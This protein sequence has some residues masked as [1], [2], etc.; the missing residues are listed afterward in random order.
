MTE[1]RVMSDDEF[2]AVFEIWKR[3]V[4]PRIEAIVQA[5]WDNYPTSTGLS[6]L[7]EKHEMACKP[8]PGKPRPK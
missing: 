2:N 6:E 8:K 5:A 4:T 1:K 3:I 7:V